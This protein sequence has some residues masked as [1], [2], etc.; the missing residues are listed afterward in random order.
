MQTEKNDLIK[1]KMA[2]YP[3]LFTFIYILYI[4]ITKCETLGEEIKWDEMSGV[5]GHLYE[6]VG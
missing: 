6:H 3:P 2:A 5:L 1:F 4:I